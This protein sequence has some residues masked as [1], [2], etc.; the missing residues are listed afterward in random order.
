MLLSYKLWNTNLI[1]SHKLINYH[2]FIKYTAKKSHAVLQRIL[3]NLHLFKL[4]L[5]VVISIP[6][7]NEIHTLKTQLR[8]IAVLLGW[9]RPQLSKCG[10]ALQ[11]EVATLLNRGRNSFV[12]CSQYQHHCS[13]IHIAVSREISLLVSRNFT[14]NTMQQLSSTHNNNIQFTIHDTRNTVVFTHDMRQSPTQHQRATKS[15]ML[16]N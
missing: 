4:H 16:K 1:H 15:S 11:M 7:L 5:N 9:W 6:K 2:K 13:F 10:G 8:W 12:S 14:P 3:Q